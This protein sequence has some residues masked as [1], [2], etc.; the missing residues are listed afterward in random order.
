MQTLLFEFR[1][2]GGPCSIHLRGDDDARM[3]QAARK[4][5]AEV[6]RIERK[7][8]RYLDDSMVSRINRSA[9][10]HAVAVDEETGQ[11][12]KFADQLWQQ[13]GGLFDITSG[14][15][16]KAW[17]FST[18]ALPDALPL[19]HALSLI[20]WDRVLIDG[21]QVR[22]ADEGMEIDFGGFGK[23]Y[24]ADRAAVMLHEAGVSN[25]LVNLGGDLHALGDP[26]T[27][28]WSIDIQ[29]PRPPA[30]NPLAHIAHVSL[31]QGGLATSGDY[32]RFIDIDGHRYCHILNPLTGWPVSAHQSISVLAPTATAAGALTTIAMLKEERGLDWLDSQGVS[33]LAVCHD[34]QTRSN[35]SL[36]HLS[37]HPPAHA[38]TAFP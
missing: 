29:H 33:Y 30:S 13:S 35:A 37:S 2:M 8:S 4:A 10:R 5:I 17:N 3:A 18:P 31:R 20:G 28:P 12:L 9:G 25:A 1:A 36:F 11:L 14:V 22:L 34:G 15:L 27:A 7:F 24:A 6:Q 32:E 26:S 23:E 21:D 38:A 19:A 16:R